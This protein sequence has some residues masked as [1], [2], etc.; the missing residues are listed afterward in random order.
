MSNDEVET[1]NSGSDPFSTSLSTMVNIFVSPLEAFDSIAPRPTFIFPLLL[2]L[3]GNIVTY[4][5]YFS[6]VDYPWLVDQLMLQLGDLPSEQLTAAREAYTS[7]TSTGMM[8]SSLVS[9][10]VMLLLVYSLQAGYLSMVS[11]LVGAP[12]RFKHWFSLNCWAYLPGL[13]VIIVSMVNIIL[14]DNGQIDIYELNSLS[15]RNLGFSGEGTT[16]SNALLDSLNLA[17]FWSLG[18][19]ITGYNAWVKSG[20]LKASIVVLAPYILI[21][22][23][24]AAIALS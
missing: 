13:L 20:Y 6:V 19:L 17:T 5:W 8:A 18:L 11:A 3:L 4:G 16:S 24:W 23:I 1:K 21:Y 2:I 22:G 15:L 12:F 14:S 9:I 7:M 10:V